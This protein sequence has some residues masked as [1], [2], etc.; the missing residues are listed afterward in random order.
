M[1]M[2]LGVLIF[3]MIVCMICLGFQNTWILG[4]WKRNEE[5][6]LR[7]LDIAEALHDFKGQKEL[8]DQREK[9]LNAFY[10]QVAEIE[11]KN[12][13]KEKEL[14][15]REEFVKERIASCEGTL[16]SDRFPKKK[17][18]PKKNPPKKKKSA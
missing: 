5:R 12:I 8:L 4:A 17:L 10:E 11:I 14:C 18:V 6:Q 9:N 16:L 13:E 7:Q 2:C 3:C 1:E 15:E